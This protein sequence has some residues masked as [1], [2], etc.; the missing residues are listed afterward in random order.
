MQDFRK[1]RVW[2]R[3]Q[4]L[5]VDLYRY[6]AEF[7]SEE[8]FGLIAQLRDAGVSV[9]SNIAESSK[10]TGRPDKARLINVSEASA[11]EILSELDTAHRLRF[12]DQSENQRLSREYD[13]LIGQIERLRQRVL[14]G[15][16]KE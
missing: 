2:Q 8:R 4:E 16:D 15:Y 6:T 10:R 13:G 7:P 14:G 12:G 1:L 9:G 5:C 11:A 3:A